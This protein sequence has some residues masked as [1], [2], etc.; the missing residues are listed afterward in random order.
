MEGCYVPLSW[1][2][3]FDEGYLPSIRFI[4][5]AMSEKYIEDHFSEIIGHASAIESR[6]SDADCTM[7]SLKADNRDIINGFQHAGEQVVLIYSD[8]EQTIKGLLDRQSGF[9]GQS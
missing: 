3:D 1:R 4:C 6:L 8:Y 7:D 5:L 9:G 2:K